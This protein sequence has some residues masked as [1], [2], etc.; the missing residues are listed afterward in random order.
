MLRLITSGLDIAKPQ[1]G[2][3]TYLLAHIPDHQRSELNLLLLLATDPEYSKLITERADKSQ[4][5]QILAIA[6]FHFST[7][8]CLLSV[9]N[10]VVVFQSRRLNMVAL[11]Q[12]SSNLAAVAAQNKAECKESKE[13]RRS[14]T[15]LSKK[16]VEPKLS[17]YKDALVATSARVGSRGVGIILLSRPRAGWGGGR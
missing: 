11:G 10:V 15:H 13:R 9:G 12:T 4:I 8:L 3:H 1:P 2:P 17:R 7:S 14:R 6:F 16:F 5:H